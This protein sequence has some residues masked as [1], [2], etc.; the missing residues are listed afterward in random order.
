MSIKDRITSKQHHSEII[1]KDRVIHRLKDNLARLA[2]REKELLTRLEVSEKE[3]EFSDAIDSEPRRDLINRV[4]DKTKGPSTAIL[5]LTDWHIGQVVK[6]EKVNGLNEFNL[7][8]AEKRIKRCFQKTL[9]RLE[10]ARTEAKIDTLVVAL[11][12]DF[13]SGAIHE[14]LLESD[15][16]S[17]IEASI[18]VR[19]YLASGIEFLSKESGCRLVVPCVSGNHGRTTKKIRVGTFEENSYEHL[20]YHNLARAFAG[21][22]GIDFLI[23]KGLHVDLMLQGRNIRFMHGHAIKYNG[24]VHGL[25]VPASKAVNAWNKS[26]RAD[27]T[28]FG[29][30]HQFSDN[31]FW[32]A[33][34]CLVGYDPYSLFIKAEY[35]PPTQT[36]GVINGKYGSVEAKKIFL[37]G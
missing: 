24:G 28:Y 27:V 5:I 20:I 37:E 9:H 6:P 32:V 31:E 25:G 23:S 18:I 10:V 12:G 14:E 22:K 3:K 17:P 29:H 8:V 1:D 35:Q 15:E 7:G 26:K 2:E 30:W 11:L 36:F 21:R 16:C 13:I 33:C 34:G 4:L 19:D